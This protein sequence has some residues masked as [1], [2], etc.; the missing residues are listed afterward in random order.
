MQSQWV[1]YKVLETT[2]WYFDKFILLISSTTTQPWLK[3]IS[4]NWKKIVTFSWTNY[5]NLCLCHGR[6]SL[7]TLQAKFDYWQRSQNLKNAISSVVSRL[8]HAYIIKEK[9]NR[10]TTIPPYVGDAWFSNYGK[11]ADCLVQAFSSVFQ[12][13]NLTN[14]HPHQLC[15]GDS[16]MQDFDSSLVCQL[17][18]R[19]I[20]LKFSAFLFPT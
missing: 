2:C 4:M 16:G 3:S 17:W 12:S 20:L 10:S 6:H 11:M 5:K 1:T 13:T 8:L 14:P 18:S 15:D 19:L 9:V 7:V